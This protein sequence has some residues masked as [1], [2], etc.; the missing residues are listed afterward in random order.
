MTPDKNRVTPPRSPN[1]Y[2]EAWGALCKAVED[3]G[4]SVDNL[5]DVVAD[6]QARLEP[7]IRQV[8]VNTQ[9]LDS[10]EK[11]PDVC[12]IHVGQTEAI[13]RAID[14]AN[15]VRVEAEKTAVRV[16]AEAEATALAVK[17]EAERAA[18]QL[19]AD[20]MGVETRL[21][22]QIDAISNRLWWVAGIIITT[23]SGGLIWCYEMLVTNLGHIK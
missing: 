10:L 17:A 14:A 15:V 8:I 12:A 5:R 16:K 11:R 7:I 19:E 1:D 18:K 23:L 2:G 4:K 6:G 9:R 20:L 22:P 21:Q 13:Q 3:W